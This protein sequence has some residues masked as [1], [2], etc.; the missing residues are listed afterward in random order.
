MK[1]LVLIYT[2]GVLM[3]LACH[4]SGKEVKTIAPTPKDSLWFFGDTIAEGNA[5]PAKMLLGEFKGKNSLQIKVTGTIEEVCPSNTCCISVDIGDGKT[6][7][8]H[9]K[10]RGFFVPENAKGKTS[11]FEGFAYKDTISLSELKHIAEKEGKTKEE[12]AKIKNPEVRLSF[13]ARGIIIKK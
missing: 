4:N 5:T 13:E 7:K 8:V 6:M 11:I 9:F 10:N 1:R 12:I 2:L 3:L